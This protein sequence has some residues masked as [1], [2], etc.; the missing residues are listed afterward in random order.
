MRGW[1]AL[2]NRSNDP[3]KQVSPYAK[4]ND[5]VDFFGRWTRLPFDDEAADLFKK[6]RSQR[7]RIGTMDLKIAATTLVHG[8]L[9]LTANLRDFRQVP[10]LQM[11][12]WLH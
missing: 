9:L 11:E 5:M 1:L 8:A 6:L 7:V 12:N 10:N 2:L 4:L 3:H